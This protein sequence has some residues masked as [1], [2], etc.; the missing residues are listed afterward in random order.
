MAKVTREKE[1]AMEQAIAQ[2][3]EVEID[4]QMCELYTPQAGWLV[5]PAELTRARTLRLS[6]P[7]HLIWLDDSIFSSA[8]IRMENK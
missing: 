6:S 7:S 5:R 3:E 8:A 1:R 2:R 4:A